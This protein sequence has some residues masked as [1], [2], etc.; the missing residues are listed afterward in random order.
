[1]REMRRR[2][3]GIWSY[4]AADQG[5]LAAFLALVGVPW[6]EM[7]RCYSLSFCAQP[8]EIRSAYVWHLLK[9]VNQEFT[10]NSWSRKILRGFKARVVALYSQALHYNSSE[11]VRLARVTRIELA[12]R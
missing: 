5:F 8:D 6:Y 9:G 10:Y 11:A 1:M 12:Q 3:H 7:P 2:R 4:D